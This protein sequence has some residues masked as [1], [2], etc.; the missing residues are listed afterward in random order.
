M[1]GFCPLASGSKGNAIFLGTPGARI[2]VDCGLSL[3]ALYEKLGQL[4]IDVQ[5][6]QAILISHEHSDHIAGIKSLVSKYKIP[7]LAN[8]ET[9]KGIVEAFGE[10]FRFKIFTTGEPFSFEDLE[11][12]PFS[13]Q[14]DTSDPVAFTFNISGVKI[15]ICTDLGVVTPLVRR[16][17]AKCDYLYIEANHEPSMVHASSRPQV[18]K[19]R[20]LSRQGHLSNASCAELLSELVDPQL[21]HIHLAHLSQECNHP[22]TALKYVRAKIGE[23]IPIAIA[24]QYQISQPIFF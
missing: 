15:G 17:L 11:I 8:S 21:R 1:E 12:T 6:I 10:T 14:H 16:H 4:N 23:A 19:D 18:Y 13:I 22:D 20:V 3:K 9:A 2:L 7:L 5:E 24:S